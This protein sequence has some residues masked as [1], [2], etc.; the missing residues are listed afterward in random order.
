MFNNPFDSFHNTVAEAKEE[1]EQLDRLLTIS[2]PRE[3]WLVAVIALLLVV[4][5]AWLFLGSVTRSVA[6]DGVLVRPGA[7]AV[8]GNRSVRAIVWVEHDVAPRIEAGM[9]AAIEL[10]AAGKAPDTLEGKVAAISPIPMSGR[11]REIDS[12]APVSVLRVDISLGESLDR[13]SL[14]GRKCRI[15]IELGRQP[16]IALLWM[17]RS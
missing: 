14:A 9:P 17:G 1:R 13:D 3:R 10:G 8:A 4:L 12:A 7:T 2:T 11:L 16:P 15:V 6:I 5:A